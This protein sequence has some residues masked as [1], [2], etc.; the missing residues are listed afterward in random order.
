ML[1]VIQNA[2]NGRPAETIYREGEGSPWIPAKLPA[3]SRPPRTLSQFKKLK[4]EA[5]EAFLDQ[6][7]TTEEKLD[8]CF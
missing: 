1:V 5:K 4:A 3:N 2:A 6:F 7:Q 8:R